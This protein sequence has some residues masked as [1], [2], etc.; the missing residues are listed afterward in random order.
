MV[1]Q[2]TYEL[3]DSKYYDT[4]DTDTTIR[5]YLNTA[6]GN[7]IT[8]TDGELVYTSGTASRYVRLQTSRTQSTLNLANFIG[9]SFKFKANIKTSVPTVCSII[10]QT[11]SGTTQTEGDTLSSDGLLEVEMSIPSDATNVIFNINTGTN[12]AVISIS[13]WLIYE[14]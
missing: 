9:K 11:P 2:E 4:F 10:C 13:D 1:L 14:I 7:S 5:Y 3:I 8:V 6:Q 12:N